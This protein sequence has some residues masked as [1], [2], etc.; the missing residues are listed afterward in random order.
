MIRASDILRHRKGDGYATLLI[1]HFTNKQ[2]LPATIVAFLTDVHE[3]MRLPNLDEEEGG[4][5][6]E[7]TDQFVSRKPGAETGT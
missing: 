4:A 2:E 1:E 6:D 3:Q 7:A 5:Y